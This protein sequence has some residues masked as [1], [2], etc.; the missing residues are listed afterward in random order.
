MLKKVE[1]NTFQKSFDSKYRDW[2]FIWKQGNIRKYLL[3]RYRWYCYPKMGKVSPFPLHVDIETTAKCNLRCPM[4][5]SRHLSQ[6]E[7]AKYGHMDFALF[8]K[9]VDECARNRVFSIRLSWRGEALITPNFAEYVRYAKV[10]KKIPNVSFLTNGSL[11]K[12]KLAEKLI[13]YGLDYI[14]VSID[15]LKDIYE[16]IRHPVKFDTVYNN[17]KTFK[18]LKNKKG[19]SK[20][21]IRITTLWPA[22][23]KNPQA[24][25]SEMRPV[26]DKIV[27]NPLKDYSLT[28]PIKEHFICQFPWER[29]FVTFGGDVQPCSNTKDTFIIGNAHDSSLREIWYGKKM[30]E[31]RHKH[32]K[33]RRIELF[34]CNRCS[35]GIDYSNL[36]QDRDWADWDPRDL[37]PN[38]E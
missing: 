20:P 26:C 8:K 30:R 32:S 12:G 33:G 37:L 11:L 19:K 28:E 31:L 6:D 18:M 24:F 22:I 38:R 17:L 29:L 35:Y 7:Y 27:S 23:A 16:V 10:I 15:G 14:S 36:W 34:P 9:L 3:N 13:D 1:I 5:P 25:Y 21:A 2:A 4:C